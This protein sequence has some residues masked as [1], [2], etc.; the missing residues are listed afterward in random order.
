MIDK[1]NSFQN[2]NDSY[3]LTDY[4]YGHS[5]D[6]DRLTEIGVPVSSESDIS[7]VTP[8]AFLGSVD[9]VLFVVYVMRYISGSEY[10]RIISART[11]E[12]NEIREY[13][14]AKYANLGW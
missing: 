3:A 1:A 14:A 12:K 4:D 10:H 7:N 5:E 11:A 13:E 9:N 8:R 6:E 2:N